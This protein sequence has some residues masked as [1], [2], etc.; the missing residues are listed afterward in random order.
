MSI[1]TIKHVV[2]DIIHAD[3]TYDKPGRHIY[4]QYCLSRDIIDYAKGD[5]IKSIIRKSRKSF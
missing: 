4:D 3:Q 5:D 1:A 2:P